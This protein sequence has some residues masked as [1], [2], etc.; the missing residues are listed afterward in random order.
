MVKIKLSA[1]MVQMYQARK[2]ATHQ[3]IQWVL[4]NCGNP[5]LWTNKDSPV[6]VAVLKQAGILAGE[7]GVSPPAEICQAFEDTL[8]IRTH[9]TD[10]FQSKEIIS[11][12]DTR[13]HEYF[14][15]S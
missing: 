9:L 11:S 6:P 2:K 13:K 10:Y 12:K 14:N 3:V 1:E 7:Q 8:K 4:S 15:T 5:D